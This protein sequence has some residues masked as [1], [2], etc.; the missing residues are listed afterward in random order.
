DLY[1]TGANLPTLYTK[2]LYTRSYWAARYWGAGLSALQ[3]KD[4]I[5]WTHLT[6]ED[7]LSANYPGRDDADLINILQTID[8][9]DIFVIFVE[10]SVDHV[11]VSW[12]AR[13]GFDVSQ[14]ALKFG[15]GGHKPAAGAEIQGSITEVIDKVLIATRSQI[16]EHNRLLN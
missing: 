7:R 16:N 11:K 15:G 2:A 3:L 12:R 6:L 1:E 10:Q 8:D 14:I 5:L 4:R 9:A 13:P